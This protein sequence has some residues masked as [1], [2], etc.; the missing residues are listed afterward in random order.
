MKTFALLA[1][2][3]Q[4]A[5]VS[6]S[7]GIVKR[8]TT[9]PAPTSTNPDKPDATISPIRA[10]QCK[11]PGEYL[12][13][14]ELV[15]SANK[16]YYEFYEKLGVTITGTSIQIGVECQRIYYVSVPLCPPSLGV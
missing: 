11:C 2:A 3:V 13:C 12:C 16:R 10:P 14:K 6:A 5:I 4:A 7:P 1:L 15:N 9:A 8:D